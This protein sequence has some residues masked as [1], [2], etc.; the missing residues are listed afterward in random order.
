MVDHHFQAGV[1]GRFFGCTHSLFAFYILLRC[2]AAIPS[3]FNA[4]RASGAGAGILGLHL[5]GRLLSPRLTGLV[6][7][8]CGKGFLLS[9]YT[10]DTRVLHMENYRTDLM[11]SC[12]SDM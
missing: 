4:L 12:S 8:H 3:F 2:I 5:H 11:V 6:Q 7:S 10:C 1:Q 9:R